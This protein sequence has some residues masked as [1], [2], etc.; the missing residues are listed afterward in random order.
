MVD[1]VENV[2]GEC[3]TPCTLKTT[4]DGDLHRFVIF[5]STFRLLYFIFISAY[6]T[7]NAT[8]AVVMNLLSDLPDLTVY[9]LLIMPETNNLET[10]C[11]QVCQ[12]THIYCV[13]SASQMTTDMFHLS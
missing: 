11:G 10:T 13:I 7:T 3:H 5:S 9:H 12:M 4:Q 1:R 6:H 8:V 2:F